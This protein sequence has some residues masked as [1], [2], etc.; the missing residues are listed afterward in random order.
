MSITVGAGE[1]FR[2]NEPL[3]PSDTV[4]IEPGG[5]LIANRLSFIASAGDIVVQ[6]ALGSEPAGALEV[7][8]V[9]PVDHTE[10]SFNA[11]V[12]DFADGTSTTLHTLGTSD[13]GNLH[14]FQVSG[15]GAFFLAHVDG[16]VTL[17]HNAH[18]VPTAF[19]L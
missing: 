11:L 12:L 10:F 9:A 15:S 2:L 16:S 17:P 3:S 4:T 1:T 7:K 19:I 18:S 14:P 8:H 6:N 5:L 13:V